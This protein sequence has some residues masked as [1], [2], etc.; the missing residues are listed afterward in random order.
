MTL[1]DTRTPDPK[2]LIPGAT[3]DW[4]VIIGM[5]VHAQVTSEAKLFSGAS[6]AFGAAPNANVSL[7]DAAMPGM[8]PV[9]NEECVRQAIRTG[10][11]LKAQ[12]NHKSVFD[13]KNYFYPD[14]PQGYQISQFKQPIV[15]EGTVIVSVGPDK[16]GEFED[17]EVGIERL[18]L[19]QDAGKSMH[20]QHPTM[21]Y[22]DLNRSGV[23]LME[24]VSKPDIRSSDEA[25]AYITKLRTIVRYLGTCDGNMDEGSLR[26]DVNVSVRRPGEGFGTRCEI[27]NMNSIR[28]IGQ[29]IEYEA[30]RQIAILEDGGTIDQETRLYDPVK[31]ET[32]SMRSKEEAHDYRYF[33]DPDLLPL[34]FDQ[35]YV[36]DLARH[37]PELP[38][39]KKTRLVEKLGLSAYDASILVSE[40][41]IADYFEQVTAGRDGKTVANWV[42]NDLLGALNKSGKAIEETPVSPAQLGS[43]VDLIREGTISGKIAK[44]LFEIVWNEGGDPKELVETR[45]MKQVTDTGAIEKAVDDVI[46]ANPDKVEQARAKPTMAGWFVGQVMKATGGKA[47]PQA[48]ND[49]VKAKLGITE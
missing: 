35:A 26:A 39:D 30:R 42:I 11:G 12:I 47:N 22:V 38:D 34:E 33:P 49:L 41:A 14:L 8:L 32:R 16:K 29:A 7:V 21:S 45:G 18:H 43:I 5:E 40:K 2:R 36:D 48:V 24:I 15:G 37:L 46:A 44:D 17:I 3:G 31:G 19:E 13:R 1:I 10:L 6:T 28:F 9:I 23:A 4:E 25:K 27:K 20:D